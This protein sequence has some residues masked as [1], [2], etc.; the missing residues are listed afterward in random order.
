LITIRTARTDISKHPQDSIEQRLIAALGWASAAHPGHGWQQFIGN[1][2]ERI[3]W[4]R[5][6]M[7]GHSSGS[8]YAAWLAASGDEAHNSVVKN[9]YE[10]NCKPQRAESPLQHRLRSR[11]AA[12]HRRRAP[13][14]AMRKAPPSAELIAAAQL[15]QAQPFGTG[16]D[17]PANGEAPISARA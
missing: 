13:R 11:L 4:P 16:A 3:R 14:L 9:E 5:V 1:G 8:S 2:S 17:A 6:T 7:A 10:A 15:A 12:H